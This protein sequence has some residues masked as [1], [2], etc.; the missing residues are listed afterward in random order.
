MGYIFNY[1]F[2]CTKVK[3]NFPDL[4]VPSIESKLTIKKLVSEYGHLRGKGTTTI[5]GKQSGK[6]DFSFTVL[7]GNCYPRSRHQTR[8]FQMRHFEKP[9]FP[10]FESQKLIK[11]ICETV[12]CNFVTNQFNPTF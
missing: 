7:R 2:G 9:H 12:V 10:C 1:F 5:F 4:L 6:F 8:R 3:N 11:L